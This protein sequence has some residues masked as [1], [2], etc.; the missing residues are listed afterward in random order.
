MITVRAQFGWSDVGSW[1]AL[2]EHLPESEL[3]R[4]LVDGGVAID[5]VNNVVYAPG[6]T[7]ALV[8]VSD[9]VV[10]D[11]GDAL[12]VCKKTDA[13]AVKDVVS[14]LEERGEDRLL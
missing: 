7:V 11:T 1:T 14:K 8:G 12:L 2:G 5:A 4:A 9:L 10:V 6:K 3:G 13:Q